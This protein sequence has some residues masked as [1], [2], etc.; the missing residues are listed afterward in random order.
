MKIKKIL[1][2]SLALFLIFGMYAFNASAAEFRF[3]K[4]GGNV[5]VSQDEEVKNL[6]TVGNMISING[7]VKKSLYVAGNVITISSNVENNISAVGNTVII[8]GSVGDSVHVG[9]GSA[10][11]EGE[12]A[13]D[14]FIAGGNI[15]ISQSASIGGD[16]IIGGGTVDIQGSVAGDIRLGGGQVIVNSKV[17]GDINAKVDELTFGSQAEIIGK[18]TYQSPKETT[19]E[20]GASLLGGIEFNE[21]KT[22]G[23][24]DGKIAGIFFLIFSIGFLIKLIGIIVVGLILIYVLKDF[25]SKVI[26]NGLTH[27]WSN[28]GR[29]FAALILTPIVCLILLITIIG[30][31]LA[32]LV[33]V[34]YIFTLILSAAFA[35]II[36]GSW[37]MKVLKKESEYPINWKV[38]VLGAIVLSLIVLIP[39]VGWIIGFA[40]VLVAL[41]A[42]SRL[43]YQSIAKK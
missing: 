5:N 24:E 18:V 22:S 14:L 6:Y 1:C 25:V 17:G 16:L 11:I 29:G 35:S 34:A 15:I 19:I 42:I 38:V 32:G 7:D 20:E 41:G 13:E 31:W 21:I 28:I 10:V 3:I 27:F 2:L 23:T 30:I 8:R 43:I 12:I 37:L 4:K 9:A 39:F 26:N 33:W 40:F 36:F